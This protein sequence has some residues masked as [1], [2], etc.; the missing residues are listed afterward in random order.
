MHAGKA[1]WLRIL[2]AVA[3]S[4]LSHACAYV[5]LSTLAKLYSFDERDFASIHPEQIRIRIAVPPGFEVSIPDSRM[6]V[7]VESAGQRR[8]SEFTLTD[9]ARPGEAGGIVLGERQTQDGKIY[10]V[11]LSD[12]SVEEFVRLQKSLSGQ[13][14]EASK[15]DISAVLARAPCDAR[16]VI[17]NVDLSPAPTDGFIPI[18]DRARVAIDRSTPQPSCTPSAAR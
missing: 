7:R 12:E 4:L 5:P 16:E 18:V 8:A 11:R 2:T 10:T 14:V 13:R 3:A 17:G 1:R 9:Q 6:D 15:I